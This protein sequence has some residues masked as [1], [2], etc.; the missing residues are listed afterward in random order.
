[1]ID[2]FPTD[3]LTPASFYLWLG[4]EGVE[5]IP[6]SSIAIFPKM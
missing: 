4:F 1:M 5:T 3:W 2:N 6:T